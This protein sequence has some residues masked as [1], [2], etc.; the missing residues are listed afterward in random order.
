VPEA[1][2]A[3]TVLALRPAPRGFEV[4]MVHR[5]S[6]GFFADIAVF[7]GGKVDE[8]DVPETQSRHD[9]PSHRNAAI[10]E[11]AEETGILIT[12]DG[13]VQAPDLKD[14]AYYRWIADQGVTTGV[15][16]LVL[17]SRWV[18]PESAPRRFDTR[19]YAVRCPD[20]PDVAI[21]TDE[22]IGHEWVT[23]SDALG[24]HERREWAMI[25][26]TLAHLRWLRRWS[27]I[28]D[29]MRSAEGADGRTVIVPRMVGDGS[30]LPIHM[31]AELP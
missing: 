11:L 7:P 27:T 23:P 1:D 25:Q 22:L 31:P 19:F 6:H 4:L 18:T 30:L 28:D 12:S 2:P 10:R 15:E 24:R 26:P 8:I 20:P 3:A 14:G 13:P 17:V 21:D 5:N 29:A 9:D 16:D